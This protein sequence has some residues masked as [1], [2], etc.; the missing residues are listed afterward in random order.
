VTDRVQLKRIRIQGFRSL[1]QVEL[2]DL[3]AATVLIGAN[4]SGKSNFIRF[5]EMLSWMQGPRRLGEFIQMNG[6][7]DDQL[8]GGSETTTRIEADVSLSTGAGRNDYRFVLSHAHPDRLLFTEECLRFQSKALPNEPEWQ[9]LGSGHAETEIG[10][11][12]HGEYPNVNPTTAR[13]IRYL[14]RTCSVF[15]FHNTSRTS[16]FHKSWD[17]QDTAYLRSDAGNLPAV[18]RWLEEED[19]ARYETI[20]DHIGRVLPTFDGFQLAERYGKVSL[21]WK[22]RVSNKTVGS[23]LTSDGSL[24]FFAL[25]TLLHL[26]PEMLPNVLLLDEPELGLHPAA[27]TL[28]GSML[29]AVAKER[30]VVVATQSPLLVDEFSLDEIIVLEL[31]DERTEA[32][33]LNPDQYRSWLEEFATGELWQK[34]LLGGRP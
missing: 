4:G 11:A 1:A 7:A 31:R 21:R 15:Q 3:P 33:R 28:V 14:L 32:Q 19:P 34:N 8:H 23:H 24:R 30:Q 13:T 27:V 20:C 18:L 26:P 29:K 22:T 25:V 6:G 5:F 9:P 17:A 12:A 2:E 10:R 16:S